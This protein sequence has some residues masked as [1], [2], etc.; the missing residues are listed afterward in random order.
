MRLVAWLAPGGVFKGLGLPLDAW[1]KFLAPGIP[2]PV[3]LILSFVS[4]L[5]TWKWYFYLV[6]LATTV[7]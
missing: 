4:S 2:P 1:D 6:P 5:V 3:F 7:G